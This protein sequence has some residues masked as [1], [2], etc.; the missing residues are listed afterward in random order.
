M[1]AEDLLVYKKTEELFY[2]IYPTFRNFPR[3]EQHSMCRFI[4]EKFTVLLTNLSLA[5]SVK[6]KRKTY[7]QEA[8]AHLVALTTLVKLSRHQRYFSNGFFEDIDVSLTEIKKLLI[9]WL[10]STT[11]PERKSNFSKG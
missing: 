1:A 9:G 5:N 8:D 3:S 2:R 11:N 4:K 6:S 10:K 7:I